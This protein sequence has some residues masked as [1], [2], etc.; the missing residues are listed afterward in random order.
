MTGIDDYYYDHFSTITKISHLEW[1]DGEVRIH[2]TTDRISKS[3]FDE[4]QKMLKE[5]RE[6]HNCSV[7]VDFLKPSAP[8]ISL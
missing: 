7:R 5:N 2:L 8:K 4:I 6:Q 1:E 3:K